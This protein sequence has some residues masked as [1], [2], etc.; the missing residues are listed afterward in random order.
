MG[1]T[2]PRDRK[3]Q[4][5]RA[6]QQ[7]FREFGYHGV[8]VDAVAA[9]VGI[10]GSALYRHYRGKQDL[11]AGVV[12]DGLT[13]FQDALEEAIADGVTAEEVLVALS[14]VSIEERGV[15]VLWQREVRHMRPSDQVE[16][17]AR[18]EGIEGRLAQVLTVR[19]P[20]GDCAR[21]RARAVL[22][23][24]WS[25]SYHHAAPPTAEFEK[26]LVDIA[27]SVW[28]TRLAGSSSAAAPDRAERRPARASRREQILAVASEMF[29]QRGFAEVNVDE[30]AAVLGVTGASVYRH[31]ATKVALLHTALARG[32][33]AL[34]LSLSR[35]L[36]SSATPHEALDRV[37]A[38]YVDVMLEHR[39]I[40]Q[41]LVT[42]VINL[43]DEAGA[44]IR[45]T[46]R[47]Y[48]GEWI[49]LLR[50]SQPPLSTDAARVV[51]HA[52]LTIINDLLRT[53]RHDEPSSLRRD[54]L[55]L[56][57]AA[58]HG[59]GTDPGAAA[60]PAVSAG[61]PGT[62]SPCGG[63]KRRKPGD[64]RFPADTSQ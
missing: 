35:A 4:I 33:E 11:L 31:F 54:A 26:L 49:H 50:E 29:A 28:R 1:A 51:V 60:G 36:S 30:I 37:L 17:R 21:Y 55:A 41:L 10:G 25:P 27:T 16:V 15:P 39:D 48:V 52:A 45:R 9:E 34:H 62:V 19:E 40:T 20:A 18:A 3:A 12:F 2:R 6:A 8:G 64:V 53:R 38:S 23:V 42:E 58:L 46:Q 56:G 43:P 5:A 59:A 22:S 63:G 24:L 44:G 14:S 7:L 61:D 57:L 47:D 32:A 13:R